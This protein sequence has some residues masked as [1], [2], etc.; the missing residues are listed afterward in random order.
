MSVDEFDKRILI[1]HVVSWSIR[2]IHILAIAKQSLGI[3]Y[4]TSSLSLTTNLIHLLN[5]KIIQ[6]TFFKEREILFIWDDNSTLQDAYH[7]LACL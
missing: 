4:T 5:Q 6:M 3:V 7:P 2:F 1:G